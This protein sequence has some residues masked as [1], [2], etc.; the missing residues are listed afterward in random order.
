M[1]DRRV[2]EQEKAAAYDAW[3]LGERMDA[4]IAELNFEA[5]VRDLYEEH[6]TDTEESDAH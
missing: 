5:S 2:S 4:Y 3:V 1:E 6:Q